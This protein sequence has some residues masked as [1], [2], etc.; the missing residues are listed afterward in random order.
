MELLWWLI[1]R[2]YILSPLFWR[3]GVEEEYEEDCLMILL[4]FIK[5]LV[6]MGVRINQATWYVSLIKL[7]HLFPTHTRRLD[8]FA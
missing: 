8:Q 5:T 2:Q 1:K 3:V 6:H 4:Q 7:P